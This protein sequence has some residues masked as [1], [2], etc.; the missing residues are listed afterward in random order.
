MGDAGVV[1]I[2]RKNLGMEGG[3]EEEGEEE[4]GRVK[5]NKNE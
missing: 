1:G 3:R 5:E 4:E 2:T